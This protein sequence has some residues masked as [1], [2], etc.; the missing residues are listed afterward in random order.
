MVNHQSQREAY[1]RCT[2]LQV[3]RSVF[4]YVKSDVDVVYGDRNGVLSWCVALPEGRKFL[5]ILFGALRD[6]DPDAFQPRKSRSDV[7]QVQAGGRQVAELDPQEG[8]HGCFIDPQ[9][10]GAE[11]YAPFVADC[12]SMEVWERNAAW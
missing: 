4:I 2:A 3:C 7:F 6:R 1:E 11:L 5:Q 8:E 12:K 10:V 9:G